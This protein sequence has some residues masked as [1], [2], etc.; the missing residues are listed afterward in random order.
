MAAR[1][2]LALA[3]S[4]LAGPAAALC[5]PGVAEFRWPGGAARFSVELADDVAER[6]RGLMH[7]AEMPAGAG[8]LFVYE[9]QQKVSFW[10]KNTLIPLD[11]I[12]IGKDGV[13][14]DVHPMAVP[15]DET[16]IPG[17]ADTLMVLEINGGLASRLGL[18]P[19]AELRHPSVPAESARWR[20]D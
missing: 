20:C 7:R 2:G 3:F 18:G 14:R 19:G 16:P 5:S 6:A 12:F 11:M 15:G 17:P 1:L 8:M 13:V 9:R 10:M 4:L